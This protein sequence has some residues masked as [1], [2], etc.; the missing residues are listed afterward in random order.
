MKSLVV[1]F[2]VFSLGCNAQTFV[3]LGTGVQNRKKEEPINYHFIR[4]GYRIKM[5]DFS[6]K[7]LGEVSINRGVNQAGVIV[8]ASQKYRKINL[9]GGISI[10]RALNDVWYEKTRVSVLTGVSVD[11]G[12]FDLGVGVKSALN[13][14]KRNFDVTDNQGLKIGEEMESIKDFGFSISFG[15][16]LGN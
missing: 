3:S 16:Y 11:I 13:G 4:G 14:Y 15:Y 9:N 5:N 7:C 10:D 1:L 8:E 2:M 12:R 6:V